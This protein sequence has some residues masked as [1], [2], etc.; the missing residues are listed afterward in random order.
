MALLRV[1]RNIKVPKGITIKGVLVAPFLPS[2]DLCISLEEKFD[3]REF[4]MSKA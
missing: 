2:S 1:Q 3:V 4:Q